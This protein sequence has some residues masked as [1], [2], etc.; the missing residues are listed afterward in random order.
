MKLKELDQHFGSGEFKNKLFGAKNASKYEYQPIVRGVEEP[1]EEEQVIEDPDSR[2]YR[3]PY[4][5]VK[6]DLDFESCRPTCKVMASPSESVM[7][8]S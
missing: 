1:D 8:S 4:I 2:P 7:P 3:P 5:K 6:I